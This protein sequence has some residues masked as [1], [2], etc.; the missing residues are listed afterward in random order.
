MFKRILVGYDDGVLSQKALDTAIELAEYTKAEI[1]IVSA[2]DIPI[3]ISSPGIL[4]SDNISN[5]KQIFD[6]TLLYFEELHEQA[7]A[8]AR[9]KGLRVT[10]RVLEGNP[11]KSLVRYAEEIDAD[12][13]VVG[14]NNKGVLDRLFLGSVSNY[15]IHHAR[16]M[17]LLAKN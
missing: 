13:I 16:C 3:I 12:I 4:P 10:T 14:S 17:I 11:G 1:F 9:E 6:N 8:K 5:N 7:A 15:V 2:V